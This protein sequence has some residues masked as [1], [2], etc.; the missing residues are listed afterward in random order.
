MR[1]IGVQ[2]TER[3]ALDGCPRHV[4]RGQRLREQDLAGGGRQARRIVVAARRKL[5]RRKTEDR[6]AAPP[7]TRKTLAAR[8]P[9]R[10]SVNSASVS[11][12]DFLQLG[13]RRNPII[14]KAIA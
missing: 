11:T 2:V 9:Y 7:V 4:Q 12:F 14:K 8:E 6:A 13:A 3:R 5:N 10:I 1:A